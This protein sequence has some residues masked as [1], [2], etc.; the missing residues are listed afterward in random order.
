[1]RIVETW[2]GRDAGALLYTWRTVKVETESENNTKDRSSEEH[3][4][5]NPTTFDSASSSDFTLEIN[6]IKSHHQF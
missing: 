2:G 3:Y 6:R 4:L 1:V 5:E